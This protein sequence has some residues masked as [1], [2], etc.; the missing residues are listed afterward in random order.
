VKPDERFRRYAQEAK[1]I[2][3]AATAEIE[4]SRSSKEQWGEADP[5][6]VRVLSSMM[7]QL[8]LADQAREF[9]L[10]SGHLFLDPQRTGHFYV[11]GWHRPG[12]VDERGAPVAFLVP[13]KMPVVVPPDCLPIVLYIAAGRGAE[14]RR[15]Y[16]EVPL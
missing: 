9:Q 2:T 3:A 7:M 4:R 11:C 1:A 10:K 16:P 8:H 6:D 13:P 15:T 5:D 14:A 12:H